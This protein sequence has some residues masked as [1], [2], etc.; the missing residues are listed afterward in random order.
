MS[1]RSLL[2]FILIVGFILLV[3]LVVSLKTESGNESVQD[4]QLSVANVAFSPTSKYLSNEHIYSDSDG[5]TYVLRRYRDGDELYL[6]QSG[7]YK[8][9][10]GIPNTHTTLKVFQGYPGIYVNVLFPG[11]YTDP[12]KPVI[13]HYKL[14]RLDGIQAT[15]IPGVGDFS[16]YQVFQTPRSLYLVSKQLS[17]GRSS[18]V[19]RLFK[20]EGSRLI[21]MIDVDAATSRVVFESNNAGDVYASIGD[22]SYKLEGSK[23]VPVPTTE[24][25]SFTFVGDSWYAISGGTIYKVDG[26]N[27]IPIKGIDGNFYRIEMASDGTTVYV[28]KIEN[29]S[30]FCG[31]D[32]CKHS[33]LYALGS[34]NQARAL[35]DGRGL[36]YITD[37]NDQSAAKQFYTD[38]HNNLFTQIGSSIFLIK[39]G[40]LLGEIPRV[41]RPDMFSD[42]EGV[43]IIDPRGSGQT[44]KL[45]I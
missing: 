28:V 13:Q 33:S 34:D 6:S 19:T 30:G 5:V 24:Y 10:V 25:L 44:R 38:R 40:K 29:A 15:V 36:T 41:T 12:K 17:E 22:K 3:T 9:I 8:P 18:Y 2:L 26:T 31:D 20:L 37:L 45:N 42:S 32:I 7:T 14:Y 27:L 4:I 21:K 43:Y 39:E 16:P 11:D 35:V 1:K 23:V